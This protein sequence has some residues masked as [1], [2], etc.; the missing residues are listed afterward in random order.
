MVA[1]FVLNIVKKAQMSQYVKTSQGPQIHLGPQGVID[2]IS[3]STTGIP[4]M[5]VS[6]AYCMLAKRLQPVLNCGVALRL[7]QALL[8]ICT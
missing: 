6:A 5:P 8:S 2:A 7:F 4:P 3:R 1:L